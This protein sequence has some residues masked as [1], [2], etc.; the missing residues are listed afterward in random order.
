MGLVTVCLDYDR[1]LVM[2]EQSGSKGHASRMDGK[3]KIYF[4]Q[5]RHAD[6][7]QEIEGMG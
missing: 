2:S 1:N 7:E 4:R 6:E 5:Q 3:F